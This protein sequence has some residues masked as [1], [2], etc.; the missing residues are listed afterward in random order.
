MAGSACMSRSISPAACALV[1]TSNGS[2]ASITKSIP[3]APIHSMRA[4]ARYWPTLA[5]GTLVP[6][7]SGIRPKLTG[8]GQPAADFMIEGPAQHGMAGLVH[9][10]G[11]ESPGLTSA[12]SIAQDVVGRL[13]KSD[14]SRMACSRG[15]TFNSDSRL[16]AQQRGFADRREFARRR[17]VRRSPA[18]ALRS[19]A[20][21]SP[22]RRVG[23]LLTSI[24]G[25]AER[26]LAVAAAIR[27][28]L[29][30]IGE[31]IRQIGIAPAVL[32]IGAADAAAGNRS[33]SAP[34][35]R[36]TGKSRPARPS[37]SAGSGRNARR[38]SARNTRPTVRR[39][40]TNARR[41]RRAAGR[42]DRHRNCTGGAD[43][44]AERRALPNRKSNS[45]CAE[46]GA[47]MAAS[48]VAAANVAANRR[49]MGRLTVT[50]VPEKQQ[51]LAVP[52][53]A[54]GGQ[55]LRQAHWSP[56]SLG[57]FKG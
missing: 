49:K 26:R 43:C 21:M 36:A 28:D 3:A 10:F 29:V 55:R 52:H 23:S 19:V 32:R 20:T 44:G 30:A 4:S 8:P 15:A 27:N 48:S 56:F 2:T 39:C 9:L 54:R 24:V 16:S 17:G 45:P 14:Q 42:S 25:E 53:N 11:I 41:D 57:R 1:L 40:K 12:L 50:L 18:R 5:D 6:D 38:R 47:G 37:H 51:N 34:P 31:R 33:W 46:A 13:K 7:Y 35:G 22:C